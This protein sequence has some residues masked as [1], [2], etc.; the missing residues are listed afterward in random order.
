MFITD[1]EFFFFFFFNTK[2]YQNGVAK[3]RLHFLALRIHQG[4]C[5]DSFHC[6]FF[7]WIFSDGRYISNDL[8]PGGYELSVSR[9]IQNP[10]LPKDLHAHILHYA[11]DMLFAKQN[12]PF[13][14]LQ[15][16]L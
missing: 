14:C 8:F 16:L 12:E 5:H 9:M 13:L 2:N 15:I 11:Q 6:I 10:W 1:L 7:L 4:H 3:V